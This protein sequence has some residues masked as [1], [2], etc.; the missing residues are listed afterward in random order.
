MMTD[1]APRVSH[2]A[3]LALAHFLLP[4]DIDESIA[5]LNHA[6]PDVRKEAE[7]AV[8][9]SRDPKGVR[10]L[11]AM[12]KDPDVGVR[13]DA[14]RNLWVM[15][16][17][18]YRDDSIQLA[19]QLP[20]EP[21]VEALPQ[22]TTG[23][24]MGL[25]AASPDPAAARALLD[26]LA[27]APR[28]SNMEQIDRTV[29]RRKDAGATPLLLEMIKMPRAASN[30]MLLQDILGRHDPTVVEPLLEFAKTKEGAWIN[31]D[32]VLLAFNDSRVVPHLLDQLKDRD[33]SVRVNAAR[34]LSSFQNDRVV[35]ALIAALQDE[36][37]TVQYAAAASLG[38]LGDP[39]AIPSLIAM[40]DYNPGAA[41]LALGDLKAVQAALKL[42]A[43]LRD[44]KATNRNEIIRGIAKLP[45]STAADLLVSAFQQS[46]TTDCSFRET[47][48]PELAK[49]QDPRVIPVLQ[50]IFLESWKPSGCLQARSVAATA[51][52]QRGAPL[53]L[54]P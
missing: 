14:L 18:N 5:L 20:V 10:P 51:L 6:G 9:N 11:V 35:P 41:A 4:E 39:R 46:P 31:T 32:Q 12:L 17:G 42:A 26:A 8:A 27:N 52:S 48:A 1:S 7:G 50:K 49:V 36:A 15:I 21:L 38:K 37:R 16:V 44:P 25:L 29:S 45:A 40:L 22:D 13:S 28:F 34:N 23:D 3:A 30:W 33:E 19:A 54:Q 43:V 47:L 24:L 53:L 2:E